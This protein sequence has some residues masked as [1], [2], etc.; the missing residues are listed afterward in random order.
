[1]ST[2]TPAA[3]VR[4][5][6]APNHQ[7]A[8]TFAAETALIESASVP[9]DWIR[10]SD[11]DPER[12]PIIE[13]MPGETDAP[14]V[15][16]PEGA[17]RMRGLLLHKLIEEALTGELREE[18]AAFSVR[19]RELLAQIQAQGGDD[20][21][22][23]PEEIAT[24]AWRTLQ[25]PEISALRPRLVPELPVYA[26]LKPG[27]QGPALAGRIDAAAIDGGQPQ[28]IVDW[29]SDVAPRSEDVGTHAAQL[30]DYLRA[31]GAPRGAL[32]YMTTGVVHWVET[33][34][35]LQAS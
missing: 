13:S 9:V 28:V 11:S 35:A 33:E 30:Q 15:E 6:E 17:G 8:A 4:G 10:P 7:D 27:P 20:D 16:V 3:L 26:W 1:M 2:L 19:A 31:T 22:P 32:V 23:D 18:A 34:L 21:L 29:K 12:A 5:A 24:T 14:E 25:L